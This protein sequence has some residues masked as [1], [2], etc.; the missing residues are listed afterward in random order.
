VDGRQKDV[1][2]LVFDGLKIQYTIRTV[3]RYKVTSRHE[4]DVAPRCER[5][6]SPT[7]D[8]EQDDDQDDDEAA[9]GAAQD[10]GE[11]ARARG[12]E[13]D[14]FESSRRSRGGASL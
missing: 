3:N 1:H 4:C 2:D 7:H 5:P 6:H 8:D 11:T 9:R 14:R 13:T 12:E 10:V